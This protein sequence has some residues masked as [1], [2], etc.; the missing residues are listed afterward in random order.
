M[1]EFIK[2]LENLLNDNSLNISDKIKL[3]GI[4]ENC[5]DVRAKAQ[6]FLFTL[7]EKELENTIRKENSRKG[8]SGRFNIWE[9]KIHADGLDKQD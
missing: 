2:Q 9:T 6:N 3:I 4:I 5:K 7:S 1:D 8:F